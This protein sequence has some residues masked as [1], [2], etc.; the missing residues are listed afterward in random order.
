MSLILGIVGT[1]SCGA[2]NS[3]GNNMSLQS[4]LMGSGDTAA[5]TEAPAASESSEAAKNSPAETTPS[6]SDGLFTELAKWNFVF[7]SGAGAWSTELWINED[8][9]FSGEYHDSEAG[10]TGEGYPLGTVYL[11]QFSG[12][13]STPEKIDEY[14]YKTTI[15]SI[16]CEQENGKEEILD[17]MK[18]IYSTPYGL[19]NA[20]DIYIYVK[21]APVNELPEVY[22]DWVNIA[23]EGSDTLPFYGIYNENAEN[24][25]SSW[26][27][28]SLSDAETD[29]SSSANTDEALYAIVDGLKETEEKAGAIEK[30]L[31]VEALTEDEMN[32][33]SGEFYSLWDSQLN[34]IWKQLKSTLDADTM[35]TVTEQE[36]EWIKQKDQLIEQAGENYS[37]SSLKPFARNTEGAYLTQ[38]RVY[39]LAE[40]LK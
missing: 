31:N 3:S 22:L 5:S 4:V 25:F 10:S 13:F 30:R 32:Q 40:Y 29:T 37:D 2:D 23:I 1:A 8:G 24:G 21:G 6:Q 11:C 19:D 18:F 12:S 35:K 33:L 9:S 15:A 39:E 16:S 36:Q 20:K 28:D 34:S 38:S 17:D 26:A 27:D 14:T 7:S